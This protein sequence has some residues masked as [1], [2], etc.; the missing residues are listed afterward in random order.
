[1]DDRATAFT[2]LLER[3]LDAHYRLAAVIL[4]DRVE[5][6][7]AVHDAALNAWRGFA[8][9]R[10][11]DRF[12]AWFGRILVNGCRDRLRARRRHP[13]VETLVAPY[14]GGREPVSDEDQTAAFVRRDALERAVASLDPDQTVVVALRFFSDLTIPQ[15]ASRLGIAEG[16]VKSRLHHAMRRLRAVVMDTEDT[17]R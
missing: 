4:G 16:T 7:D 5:A 13:V 8:G 9:L 12:D 11:Q 3:G 10:E 2:E 1:M 14:P 6:E 15:I 17:S